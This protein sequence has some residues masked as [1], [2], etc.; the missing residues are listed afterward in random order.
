MGPRHRE[1]DRVKFQYGDI[2]CYRYGE[3]L[4]HDAPIMYVNT[5]DRPDSELMHITPIGGDDDWDA[6]YLDVKDSGLWQRCTCTH[7]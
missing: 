5:I 6:D 7:A 3:I 1:G 4:G 2:I